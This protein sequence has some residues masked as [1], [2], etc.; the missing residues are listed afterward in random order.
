MESSPG[1]EHNKRE[2][3]TKFYAHSSGYKNGDAFYGDRKVKVVFACC[4]RLWN[5]LRPGSFPR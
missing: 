3:D 2:H 1:H 5:Q 4:N